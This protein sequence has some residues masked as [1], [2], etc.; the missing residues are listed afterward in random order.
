MWGFDFSS[1]NCSSNYGTR[2]SS[3]LALGDRCSS[4][5]PALICECV[6]QRH[7]KVEKPGSTR[8][9]SQAFV[10]TIQQTSI[11]QFLDVN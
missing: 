1:G 5:W 3:Y 6:V 11:I 7:Q 8:N 9:Q 4:S 10:E 2:W